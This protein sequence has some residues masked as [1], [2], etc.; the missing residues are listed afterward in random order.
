MIEPS[1]DLM[2]ELSVDF[3]GIQHNEKYIILY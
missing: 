1:M 3:K 2:I